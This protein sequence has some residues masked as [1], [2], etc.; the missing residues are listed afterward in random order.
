MHTTKSNT[1][2]YRMLRP[3]ILWR[4]DGTLMQ[5]QCPSEIWLAKHLTNCDSFDHRFLVTRLITSTFV[6]S[7]YFALL[8]H[9]HNTKST[10]RLRSTRPIRGTSC[11]DTARCRKSLWR[12]VTNHLQ[13]DYF[14]MLRMPLLDKK[15]SSTTLD[16]KNMASLHASS[17]M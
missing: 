12:D 2:E 3:I 14:R 5:L 6:S 15:S 8:L 13:S 10:T 9:L 16:V 4:L 1:R 7:A 11:R 17:T